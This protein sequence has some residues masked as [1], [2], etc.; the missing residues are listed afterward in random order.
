MPTLTET[1]WAKHIQATTRGGDVSVILIENFL[2]RLASNA[3]SLRHKT[4]LLDL[5]LPLCVLCLTSCP[6]MGILT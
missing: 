5:L 3:C 6:S 2:E 1:N 4:L